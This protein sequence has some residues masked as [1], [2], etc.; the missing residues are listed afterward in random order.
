MSSYE[1]SNR[2]RI[3]NAMRLIA[4]M[5]PHAL[6]MTA[7]AVS[8][9]LKF[10]STAAAALI[11]ARM[12]SLAMT[13]SLGP[14]YT[15]YLIPL[16]MCVFLR[17][18]M[19]FNEMYFGH[20]AA[21]RIQ[22]D[23][24]IEIYNKFDELSPAYINRH[25]TA[26]LGTIAMGDIELLEWFIAHTFGTMISTGIITIVFV[27]V[28]FFLDVKIALI[29]LLFS[30]VIAMLPQLGAKLADQQGRTVRDRNSK[31]NAVLIEGVQGITDFIALDYLD[32]YKSKRDKVLQDLYDI[33]CDYAKRVGLESGLA[34]F[35]AGAFSV[36]IMLIC[37]QMVWHGTMTREMYPIMLVI[38]TFIFAPILELSTAIRALGEVFGAAD[39]IQRLF[40]EKPEV[41]D[42]GSIEEI[43]MQPEIEFEDVCFE[44]NPGEQVLHNVSFHI[45]FGTTVALVGPSGAGKT[46]CSNLLLRYW[47]PQRGSIRIG[48]VDLRDMKLETLR[49]T[50]SA[51]LQDVFLFHISVKDN[52]RMGRP[53]A[54]DEE[55]VEAAK[56]A[57]AHEFIMGLPD[58]YD[59]ITGERGFRLSGG[60]RQR[61]SIA[62]ALLRN[63]PILVLDE[64]VS[65]LDTIN[66]RLIEKVL[67]NDTR[68]KTTIVIAH[69]LSTI[70]NAD[71]LIVIK[72]GNVVQIGQHSELIRQNGFYKELMGQQEIFSGVFD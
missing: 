20:D 29:V 71:V 38:S 18:I 49:N 24:R 2:F 58:G 27:I 46:T 67:K 55:V 53:D 35:F 59:T 69:R 6:E 52:I 62:R 45:P 65:N 8:V 30:V 10:F 25:H 42:S 13:H 39:R 11:T 19:Y 44:Y 37:A 50:T 70:M 34:Q 22:R 23:T 64:A 33:K 60:Q 28:L 12:V 15:K 26:Q 36:L 66:E 56:K 40:D 1:H 17:A 31:A 48:G 14:S 51:V 41:I 9:M 61:I 63:A 7:A 32:S 3:K 47:D 5:K 43:T 21:Y 57:F 72:D 68:E 16:I 54:T 4:S